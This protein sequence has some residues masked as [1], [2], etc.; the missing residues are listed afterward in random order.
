MPYLYYFMESYIE[1]LRKQA[2]GGVIKYIKLGNLTEALIKLPSID[3]QKA[4]VKLLNKLS[5]ILVLRKDEISKLDELIR[6][7]FFV[8]CDFPING[9]FWMRIICEKNLTPS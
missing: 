3:E 9:N 1:E 2:I 6:A 5:H 7:R 8:L 4:I